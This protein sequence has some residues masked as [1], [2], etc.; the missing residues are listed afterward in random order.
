M[1]GRT[2]ASDTDGMDFLDIFRY[3]HKS[4]HRTERL[5]CEIS[6]KTGASSIPTTSTSLE[7]SSILAGESIGVDGMLCESCDTTWSSEYLMSTAGLYI[8]TFWFAKVALFNL[9]ISSSVFPENIDPQITSI[10]P[11]FFAFSKN[12]SLLL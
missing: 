2:S 8:S 7:R 3:R 12:I 11:A 10:E 5:A 1:L 9:L 6:V 4:R